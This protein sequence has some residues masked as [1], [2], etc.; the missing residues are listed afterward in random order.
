[1][2]GGTGGVHLFDITNIVNPWTP[3]RIATVRA[4]RPTPRASSTCVER[5]PGARD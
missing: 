1:V 2:E 4:T 3:K 5:R